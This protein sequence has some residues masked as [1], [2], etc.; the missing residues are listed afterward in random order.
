[1]YSKE[2]IS[3]NIFKC[4][5]FSPQGGFARV[6]EVTDMSTNKMYAL[7]VVFKARLTRSADNYSKV[8][9]KNLISKA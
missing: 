7:K 5:V 1:M 3:G 4:D 6:Y 2:K 9:A 8:R